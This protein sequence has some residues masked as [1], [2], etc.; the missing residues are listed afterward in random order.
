[1]SFRS[2]RP[3][4]ARG[5]QLRSLETELE[6]VEQF[7]DQLR[8]NRGRWPK[9]WVTGMLRHYE[10]RRAALRANISRKRGRS[11]GSTE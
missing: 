8:H 5:R 7:L 4:G 2:K 11:R 10:D 1:M 9:V 3:V 6:G